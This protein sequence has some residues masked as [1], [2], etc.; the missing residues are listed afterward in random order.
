VKTES[1]TAL[2]IIGLCWPL[3][4]WAIQLVEP[5]PQELS[6]HAFADTGSWFGLPNFWN[7]LTNLALVGAGCLGLRALQQQHAIA[8]VVAKHM[9][10]PLGE[11]IFFWGLILTGFG[12][13]Y[14]HYA[15]DN[16]SLLWDR[17]PMT[18]A[19]MALF[20][21]LLGHSFERRITQS[22]LP[23]ALIVGAA[24]VL[25]WFYG[26]TQGAGDLRYYVVVQ[27]L[28]MLM[29][30]IILLRWPPAT[31]QLGWLW[32]ML[33]LYLAAKVFEYFDSQIA[34]YLPFQLTGHALKHLFAGAAG[35]AFRSALM[36]KTAIND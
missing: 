16:Q 24:S 12:S 20:V 21:T 15:P 9:A 1:R 30:P 32:S 10:R 25:F 23:L 31:L 35:L 19:F 2:L 6:Y 34:E 4:F 28:P 33:L 3:A 11:A 8:K 14:Y 27:F 7:V 17:L 13:A 29:I 5:I 36:C 22:F 18:V 26:E